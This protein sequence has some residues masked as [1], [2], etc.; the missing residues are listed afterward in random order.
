FH[1]PA[2]CV[3]DGRVAM[4]IAMTGVTCSYAILHRVLALLR[5]HLSMM[6][7]LMPSCAA[8]VR[9]H[10]FALVVFAVAYRLYYLVWHAFSLLYTRQESPAAFAEGITSGASTHLLVLRLSP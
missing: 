6:C 3:C 8:S 10:H 5:A 9:V 1:K 7:F 2:I 4:D